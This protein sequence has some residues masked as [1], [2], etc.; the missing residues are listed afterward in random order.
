M[1][2]VPMKTECDCVTCRVSTCLCFQN[3]CVFVRVLCMQFDISF[4]CS[5][6]VCDFMF[7]VFTMFWSLAYFYVF[8]WLYFDMLWPRVIWFNLLQHGLDLHFRLCYSWWWNKFSFTKP[9]TTNMCLRWC[10]H[11]KRNSRC[12]IPFRWQWRSW[13]YCY[14]YVTNLILLN[15][16]HYIFYE[17]SL[18]A[19]WS[20]KTINVSL[21][22]HKSEF[23]DTEYYCVVLKTIKTYSILHNIKEY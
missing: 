17:Q 5:R 14:N 7:F 12:L 4:V 2:R 16:H 13:K 19:S 11:R 18:C 6:C 23:Y 21:H 8:E 15:K 3:I 9:R 1:R 10:F 22:V 20:I